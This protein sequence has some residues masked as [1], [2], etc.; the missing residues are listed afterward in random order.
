MDERQARVQGA[1]PPPPDEDPVAVDLPPL[2]PPP[3]SLQP[4]ARSSRYAPLGWG[5]WAL[6]FGLFLL[7]TLVT[8]LLER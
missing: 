8:F 2:Q 6:I 5:S 3:S 4:N 1:L 7:G